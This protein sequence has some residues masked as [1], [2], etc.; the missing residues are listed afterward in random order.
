MEAGEPAALPDRSS[1]PAGPT[2]TQAVARE[3][4]RH[5]RLALICGRYEGIDERVREHLVTDQI[6]IGDYVLSGGELAAMVVVDAV[7]RLLPGALGDPGRPAQRLARVRAAGASALYPA[8]RLSRLD[9]TRDPALWTPR[10]PDPLAARGLPA[11]HLGAPPRPAARRQTLSE[12]DLAYLDTL[13][14]GEPISEPHAAHDP[15]GRAGRSGQE[16]D[17]DRVRRPDSDHRR[18]AN[19]PRKRH[20][21][22]RPGP[23]RLMGTCWTKKTRSWRSC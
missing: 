11:P 14:G 23:A 8:G 13:R 22:H 20:A 19:V 5:E 9:R 3:L 18:R 2:L 21:G 1:D 6:S 15:P 7:T 10:Q 16:Y 4:A 12:A 17:G